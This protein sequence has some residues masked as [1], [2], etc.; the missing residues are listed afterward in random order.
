MEFQKSFLASATF[1]P[2]CCPDFAASKLTPGPEHSRT[3]DPGPEGPPYGKHR[4]PFAAVQTGR[5]LRFLSQGPASGALRLHS[6][7]EAS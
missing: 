7:E 4:G 5:R 6:P 3:P 1:I 2:F